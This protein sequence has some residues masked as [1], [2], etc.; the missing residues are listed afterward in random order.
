ME[1]LLTGQEVSEE[2]QVPERTLASWRYMGRGPAFIRVGKHVRYARR[3]VEK[4]L[5]A[6]RHEA[7]EP[8]GSRR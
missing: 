8:D 7:L 4:W 5:K 3:D 2:L 6:N 1:D